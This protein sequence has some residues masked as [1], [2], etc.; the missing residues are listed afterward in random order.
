MDFTVY[1]PDDI[2]KRAKEAQDLNLSRLLR[3]AVTRELERREAMK[4]TLETPTTH[5]VY[6]ED[7][8]GRG[9]TGRITGRSIAAT[10]DHEE[11]E[12]FLTTDERVIVYYGKKNEYHVLDNPAE[13]LREWLS[14]APAAY[15]DAMTALGEEPVMDL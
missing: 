12:V 8:D 2:G 14:D 7:R 1:L 4:T 6:V 15:F 10:E 9:Y 3:D 11:I 5:E 13:E